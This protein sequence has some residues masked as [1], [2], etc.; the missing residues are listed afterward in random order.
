MKRQRTTSIS[1]KLF[2]ASVLLMVMPCACTGDFEDINVSPTAVQQDR[3]NEN[4]LFTRSLVYGALRYTEFQRAHHLY[5]N[6]YI[7]YYA[8]SVARFETDR[9]ITRND[10]LTD[11]W[12]EAYS[13]FG[14]QC[15]QTIEIA[16]KNPD[17]VNKTAIARI[18]KVFI[19]HR[20]TDLWGDVPY[21]DAFTGNIIPSY[22]KQSDIYPKML[23]EL[24]DAV[25]SFDASK[26]LGFGFADLVYK[27]EII[28]WIKFAN[29]LRFR[30][31]MR[32]SN[33]AP[34]LAEQHVKEVLTDGRL[35]ASNAESAVMP[36]GR[37]FGNADENVQPMA[38]I[39]SFN[40]Y[41]AS[42]TLV[43]FLKNNN[44]PRLKIYIEPVAGGQYVGLQNGLSPEA[45]N[46]LNANSYSKESLIISNLYAP[47]SLLIYPEVLFLKAEAALKGWATGSAQQFYEDGI[48]ASIN[49]W[50]GVNQNLLTRIPST[51]IPTLPVISI[52]ETAITTYLQQP[53]IA[54]NSAKALEQIIT[55]K[56]LANINQGF[57]AYADY[58]RT[59][60]PLLNA[61]PN[62]DG[63]SETGGSSVPSRLR[64]PAEEQT[65]N[66]TNYQQAIANQGPDLMT[67]KVW[68]DK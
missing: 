44:D 6:H 2:T 26:T 55:Q 24:R 9:Y 58:R 66:R 62:T 63:L 52:S 12:T 21:T 32:I 29:T 59:G 33:V 37:D 54:F 57:E 10:W 50:V 4:L 11:Y 42:N 45:L 60:F 15:Q 68:W 48:R 65:L 39:R 36:Y 18:W 61:I 23:N 43:D 8:T 19:M 30:L 7:Q 20:I 1:L 5:A 27:S 38:L 51:D 14:M 28:L 35:I 49:Y 41:R 40:E 13:D 56:W 47:S 17:K 16:S 34:A 64:Y 53:N 31:A 25:A 46:G 67:T 22:E 3:F